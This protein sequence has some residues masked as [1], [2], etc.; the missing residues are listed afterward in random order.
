MIHD[1]AIIKCTDELSAN[2][3]GV[4]SSTETLPEESYA[5]LGGHSSYPLVGKQVL[6]PIVAKKINMDMAVTGSLAAQPGVQ[7]PLAV[8][9]G[10]FPAFLSPLYQYTDPSSSLTP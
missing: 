1:Q 4:S 2:L 5:G 9:A 6:S 10:T 3:Y 8:Y 7:T